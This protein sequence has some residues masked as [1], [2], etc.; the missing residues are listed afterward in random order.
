LRANVS[1]YD[2]GWWRQRLFEDALATTTAGIGSYR[3]EPDV[4]V[5]SPTAVTT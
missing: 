5:I 1:K 2:S 3:N 4:T